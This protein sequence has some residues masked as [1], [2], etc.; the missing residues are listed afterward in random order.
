MAVIVN[1]QRPIIPRHGG[2]VSRLFIF[3]RASVR[4][5]HGT[6]AI[7]P[8]HRRTLRGC[9]WPYGGWIGFHATA[10]CSLLNDCHPRPVNAYPIGTNSPECMREMEMRLVAMP[11][12]PVTTFVD[13]MTMSADQVKTSS[14]NPLR[15]IPL[16]LSSPGGR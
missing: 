8:T 12:R 7:R 2:P 10:P 3:L 4:H 15:I 14:H 6:S 11:M 5:T 9:L 16:A 13:A 1:Q